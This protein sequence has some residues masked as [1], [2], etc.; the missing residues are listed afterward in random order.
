MK[1]FGNKRL[2]TTPKAFKI[3]KTDSIQKID[4]MQREL[5]ETIR[6]LQ[7]LYDGIQEFREEK[8]FKEAFEE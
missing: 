1:L 3:K 2:I 6:K 8:A 4:E 5:K 7:D